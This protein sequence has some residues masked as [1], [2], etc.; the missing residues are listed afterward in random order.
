MDLDKIREDGINLKWVIKALYI[1]PASPMLSG[2]VRDLTDKL[3]YL[4]KGPEA[5]SLEKR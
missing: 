2:K 5:D 1:A 3:I 4:A